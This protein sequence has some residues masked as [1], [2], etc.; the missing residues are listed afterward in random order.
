MRNTK[1]AW[2]DAGTRK[3]S[4]NA[5]AA[6]VVMESYGVQR[7]MYRAEHTQRMDNSVFVQYTMRDDWLVKAALVITLP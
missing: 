1:H 4:H 3:R 2:L 6:E 5:E 7:A